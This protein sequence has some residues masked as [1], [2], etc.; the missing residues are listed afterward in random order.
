M[1]EIK[2]DCPCPK[3]CSNHGKCD[4]CKPSHEARGNLPFCEREE[5]S[6]EK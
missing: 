4:V 3:D 1:E 2:L 6:D 5:S